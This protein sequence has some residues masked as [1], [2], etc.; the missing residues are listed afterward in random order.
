M[1]VI[2]GLAQG[3][4]ERYETGFHAVRGWG[5]WAQV[6]FQA[7]SRLTFNLFGGQEDDTSRD[8][9]AGGITK[10]Q[11]YGLNAIYRVMSNVL[12]SFEWSYLTT[13]YLGS[14]VRTNPHYDVAFAYLF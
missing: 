8:L 14:G 3:V 5:G 4:T 10:N 13:S 12:A 11:S 9:A 6:K 2:G 1:G 7:T